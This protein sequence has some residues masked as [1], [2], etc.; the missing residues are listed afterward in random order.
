MSDTLSRNDTPHLACIMAET[1]SGPYYIAT[2]PTLQALE[3][4]GRILRERNSVRGEKEDPV[5]ILAV[6][7][8][9]CENEV[10]ALLRAAE[11]SQLSHCWQRGLIESF[12]PQWL[13]LS[14]VSV[15]FPWIFTLPE[16]K[17]SSY[18][19]VTDL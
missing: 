2:A 9:E 5:A 6:W 18:H 10:A 15:G 7:Y 4:L 13:D 8:E 11:I 3:G 16:R 12:N 19:L 17:G 1:R 14:G